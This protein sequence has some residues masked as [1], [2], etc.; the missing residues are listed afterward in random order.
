MVVANV[1]SVGH[2]G[3]IELASVQLSIALV[4]ALGRGMLYGTPLA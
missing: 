1:I 4:G 3:A 2:L